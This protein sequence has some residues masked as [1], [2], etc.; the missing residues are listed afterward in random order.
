MCHKLSRW[1]FKLLKGN[2]ETEHT[3]M[4]VAR[5]PIR[6]TEKTVT[7]LANEDIFSLFAGVNH[8][9]DKDAS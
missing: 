8:G 2:A 3:H 4:M 1:Q 9:Q 5:Q 7:T 6:L